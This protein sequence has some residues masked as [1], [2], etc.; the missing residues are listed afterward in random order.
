MILN[1]KINYKLINTE[2]VIININVPVVLTSAD[3]KKTLNLYKYR[4]KIFTEF[5]KI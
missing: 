3:L 4:E 2:N 5:S 1:K